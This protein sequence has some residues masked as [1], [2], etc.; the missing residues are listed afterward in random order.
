[1]HCDGLTD[2]SKNNLVINTFGATTPHVVTSSP[3]P[4]FGGGSIIISTAS[5]AN[6]GMGVSGTAFSGLSTQSFTFECWIYITS[7]TVTQI[8]V[9]TGISTGNYPFELYVTTGGKLGFIVINSAGTIILNATGSTTITTNTWHF[10]QATRN[11]SNFTS[12]VDGVS[13]STLSSAANLFAVGGINL[14]AFSYGAG[15][16]TSLVGLMDEIRIT[17][18]NVRSS[19]VPTGPFP[20]HGL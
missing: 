11:G 2:S 10:I 12:Y 7:N 8:I 1:M 17:V 13:Q 6:Q 5:T 14:G 3:S 9:N 4:K 15:S 19:T 20:A 16:A 18:N